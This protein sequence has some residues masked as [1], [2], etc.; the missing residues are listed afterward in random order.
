[1]LSLHLCYVKFLFLYDFI[2]SAQLFAFSSSFSLL[3]SP[4]KN[5]APWFYCRHFLRKSH[6]PPKMVLN[7]IVSG[8]FA[9]SLNLCVFNVSS[10]F[11]IIIMSYPCFIFLSSILASCVF[12]A[13]IYT[14]T[15]HLLLGPLVTSFNLKNHSS[16]ELFVRGD[17]SVLFCTINS[18]FF[19]LYISSF[20]I[21]FVLVNNCFSNLKKL[22]I[23]V[24]IKLRIWDILLNF[25]WSTR[26]IGKQ[27][28]LCLTEN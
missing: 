10:L 18:K 27:S 19:S 17:M 22:H 3:S 12:L 20:V 24:I 5:Q 1:M 4:L 23:I 15:V 6:F 25:S 7:R 14:C 9:I 26:W 16:L 2:S 21:Y 13:D 11:I 28:Y 8:M